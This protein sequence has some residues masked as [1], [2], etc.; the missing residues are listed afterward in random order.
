[1]VVSPE[2]RN[3]TEIDA[4]ALNYM[5]ICIAE[6]R[7]IQKK[8]KKWQLNTTR[9]ILGI[10]FFQPCNEETE[11]FNLWADLNNVTNENI[12]LRAGN[13]DGN[14]KDPGHLWLTDKWYWLS[15]SRESIPNIKLV[16]NNNNSGR[17]IKHVQSTIECLA[18]LVSKKL[19]D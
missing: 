13:G 8:K 19:K 16:D 3:V 7:N 1:M 15:S 5:Y 12:Q 10:K 14:E 2:S 18:A 11:A 17:F 6:K 9:K 4:L